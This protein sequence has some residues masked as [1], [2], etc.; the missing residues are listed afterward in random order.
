MDVPETRYAR[1]GDVSVAYQLFGGAGGS[2][3]QG[4][5]SEEANAP[6]IRFY[7]L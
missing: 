6:A 3:C 5:S 4:G 7:E 2:W 1:S